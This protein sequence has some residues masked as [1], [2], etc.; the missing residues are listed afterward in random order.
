MSKAFFYE[1]TPKDSPLIF[2]YEFN[3]TYRLVQFKRTFD[4]VP[5]SVKCRGI[6]SKAYD[7][8]LF[9]WKKEK[10]TT[11][12]INIDVNE[13]LRKSD[14]EPGVYFPRM[15]R[16]SFPGL[17]NDNLVNSRDAITKSTVSGQILFDKLFEIFTYVEP[18]INKLDVYSHKLREIL[19]LACM[20][21]ESC[22]TAILKANG[23]N[24][25]N[26][27]TKQYIKLLKPMFL[28][29][30]EA[31]F[32]MY[33]SLGKIVPFQNW[34]EDSTTQSLEWY[35]SYNE[36]KHNREVNFHHAN[37]KNVIHS[38]CGVAVMLYAQFGPTLIPK[39]LIV[40]PKV[41]PEWSYIPITKQ[42]SNIIHHDNEVG[43]AAFKWEKKRF[44]FK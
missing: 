29:K 22:W 2:F 3:E 4:N 17:K 34:K 7:G 20:E 33:P 11:G 14:I 26:Y 39:Q 9:D 23:Y 21:V 27:S 6:D 42:I 37:L 32:T 36:T 30:Y 31:E 18:D 35:N 41:G 38:V 15:W 8:D 10:A 40:T 25:S 44:D 28:D 24:S 1:N 12:E 19:L 5:R 16:G 43:A 13:R